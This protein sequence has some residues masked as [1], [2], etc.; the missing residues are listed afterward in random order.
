VV[1]ALAPDQADFP[2][3]SGQAKR[4]QPDHVRPLSGKVVERQG[5]RPPR[6]GWMSKSRPRWRSSSATSTLASASMII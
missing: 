3:L 6:S 1:L 4:H 2:A 5:H